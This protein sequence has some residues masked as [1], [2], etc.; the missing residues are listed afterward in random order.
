MTPIAT[1]F[2]NLEAKCCAAC[3]QTISEQAESYSTECFSCQDQ[4]T[5]DAYKYYHQ[6]R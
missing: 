6:K 1:F 5:S 2:R 3:G 4:S